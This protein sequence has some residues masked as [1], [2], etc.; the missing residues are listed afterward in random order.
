[1]VAVRFVDG[2]VVDVVGEDYV[3]LTPGGEVVRLSGAAAA[4][5]RRML[6]DASSLTSADRELLVST[7]LVEPFAG[8]VSRRGVVL[9]AAAVAGGGVVALS[10][11]VAAAA[12]SPV[13]GI[14][15]DYLAQ[16]DYDSED[17]GPVNYVSIYVYSGPLA[18]DTYRSPGNLPADAEWPAELDPADSW[19]LLF[20]GSS[21]PLILNPEEESLRFYAEKTDD[22]WSQ[23]LYDLLSPE[24][25]A[26][27]TVQ[28]SIT[29]GS[30]TVPVTLWAFNAPTT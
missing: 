30:V 26:G 28:L 9:G 1:M 11:P 2:V 24:W 6:E 20:G 7:G 17:S 10:L 15:G 8:G 23:A 29:N 19:S 13:G 16:P 25:A 3:V 27:R 22:A 12:S 14:W 4:S 21:V 5:V 18:Y